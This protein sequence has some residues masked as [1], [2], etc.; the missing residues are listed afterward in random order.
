MAVNSKFAAGIVVLA[1]LALAGCSGADESTTSSI[2]STSAPTSTQGSGGKAA[3]E[4]GKAVRTRTENYSA[5]EYLVISAPSV[6]E[7]FS[8]HNGVSEIRVESQAIRV[9]AFLNWTGSVPGTTWEFCMEPA[10]EAGRQPAPRTPCATGT[11]PLLL[12][13]DGSNL[14]KD[15]YRPIFNQATGPADLEGTMTMEFIVTYHDE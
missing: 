12:V 3:D 8:V 9:D 15:V 1:V 4:E 11:S 14:T 7:P 6:A 2:T 10:N 5:T 13:L